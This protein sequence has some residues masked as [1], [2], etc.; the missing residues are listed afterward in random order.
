MSGWGPG[1]AAAAEGKIP[2]MTGGKI[3]FFPADCAWFGDGFFS[4]GK[5]FR[6][7]I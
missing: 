3:R 1:G 4:A 2:K 7:H 5:N 6:F